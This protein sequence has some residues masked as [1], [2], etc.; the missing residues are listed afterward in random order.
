MKNALNG[1]ISRPDTGEQRV[2]ET[3]EQGGF[4]KETVLT[5]KRINAHVQHGN[6]KIISEERHLAFHQ[7]IK[8][9]AHSGMI[10]N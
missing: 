3:E 8:H 9:E 1:L 4:L 6:L 5:L 2:G 7:F 10:A